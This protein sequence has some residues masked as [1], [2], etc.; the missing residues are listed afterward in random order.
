MYQQIIKDC[1]FKTFLFRIKGKLET[2]QVE[3]LNK[4]VHLL[5]LFSSIQGESKARFSIMSASPID[6]EKDSQL[7]IGRIENVYHQY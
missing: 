6:T 2:Y 5:I 1:T 7:M 4:L 3:L